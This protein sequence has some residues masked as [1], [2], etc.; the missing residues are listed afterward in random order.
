[1]DK[2]VYVSRGWVKL[3]LFEQGMYQEQVKSNLEWSGHLKAERLR[4]CA[5]YESIGWLH[6]RRKSVY[7]V[8][9]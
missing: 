2:H 5:I 8:T 9:C 6:I 1:M 4:L 3:G 7:Y